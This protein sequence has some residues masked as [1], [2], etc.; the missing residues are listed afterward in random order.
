MLV[1]VSVAKIIDK[2]KLYNVLYGVSVNE[3]CE[4]YRTR[5]WLFDELTALRHS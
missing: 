2:Q 1:R 4:T 3:N 5:T